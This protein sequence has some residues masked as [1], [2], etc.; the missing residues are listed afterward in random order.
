MMKPRYIN[1]L[2]FPVIM[3]T[4][5][6]LVKY[7]AVQKDEQEEVPLQGL[8]TRLG[9]DSGHGESAA[10][11]VSALCSLFLHFSP[12]F[13]QGDAETRGPEVPLWAFA[14]RKGRR[15]PAGTECLP[16]AWC[17]AEDLLEGPLLP[18]G[19]RRQACHLCDTK[20]PHGHPQP[21]GK[22]WTEAQRSLV[23]TTLT[24]TRGRGRPLPDLTLPWFPSTA[25]SAGG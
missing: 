9:G 24:L 2:S 10:V 6:C 8:Q 20:T 7:S 25:T 13:R 21:R 23:W 14:A 15:G 19:L 11:G 16:F 4:H 12:G 17:R 3:K 22:W 18:E 5:V 1:S